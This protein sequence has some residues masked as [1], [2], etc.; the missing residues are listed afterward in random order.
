VG[1]LESEATRWRARS[2]SDDGETQN[3][4]EFKEA[5]CS[6]NKETS[7]AYSQQPPNKRKRKVGEV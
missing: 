5:R 7:A 1:E 2:C 4:S 6:R 3:S